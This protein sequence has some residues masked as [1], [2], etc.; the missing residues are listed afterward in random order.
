MKKRRVSQ[1]RPCRWDDS[2]VQFRCA[3]SDSTRDGF[4]H[5]IRAP[6]QF[7]NTA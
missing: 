1:T 6:R 7:I 5:K 2:Q 3:L 4:A